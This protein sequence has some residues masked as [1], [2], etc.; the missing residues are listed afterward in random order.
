MHNL[1]SCRKNLFKWKKEPPEKCD[2]CAETDI[3][4]WKHVVIGFY[5]ELNQNTNLLNNFI[6][7]VALK[8]FKYKMFCRIENLQETEFYLTNNVKKCTIFRYRATIY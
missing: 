6:S 7:F 1:L 4:K 3:I 8:I 2:I 5:F